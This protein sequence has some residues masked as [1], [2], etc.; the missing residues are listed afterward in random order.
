MLQV[1]SKLTRKCEN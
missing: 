1:V